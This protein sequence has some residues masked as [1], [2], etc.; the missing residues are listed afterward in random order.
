MADEAKLHSPIRS[1]FEVLVVWHAVRHCCE[2]LGLFCWPMPAADVAIFSASHW[3]ALSILLRCNGFARF[4]K[5]DQAGSRPPVTMTYFAG[6]LALGSDLELVLGPTTELVVA[7]LSYKI[8]FLSHATIRWRNGL[9]LWRIREDNMT[10]L[11]FYL[12]SSYETP[13]Y[14]AFSLFQFASNAQRP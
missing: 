13:T 5:M 7:S 4:R 10:K 12:Q 14:Q 2:E 3:F 8:H 11:F 1:T 9:F 6:S